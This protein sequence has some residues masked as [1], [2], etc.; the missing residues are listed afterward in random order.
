MSFGYAKLLG[1]I[2]EKGYTQDALAR[3][4]GRNPGTLSMKLTNQ[5]VFTQQE[6]IAICDALDIPAGDIGDY[7]FSRE[8]RI[9]P[10]E[11]TADE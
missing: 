7:F 10:N 8:V 11:E 6:I 2:R 5:A 9:S 1:R 3:L 4:I